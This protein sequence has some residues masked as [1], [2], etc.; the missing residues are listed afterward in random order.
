[1]TASGLTYD[2]DDQDLTTFV[3]YIYAE[4]W[5]DD[6]LHDRFVPEACVTK[7]FAEGV[8]WRWG[9]ICPSRHAQLIGLYTGHQGMA[10]FLGKFGQCFQV[11]AWRPK[12]IAVVKSDDDKF[13]AYVSLSADY[14]IRASGISL[15][16][17]ELHVLEIENDASAS[18]PQI[19]SV[20]ILFDELALE[21]ALQS[22][23]AQSGG[24]RKMSKAQRM[25]GAEAPAGI[26]TP[27]PQ[28]VRRWAR[29]ERDAQ[30]RYAAAVTVILAA[31][32]LLGGKTRGLLTK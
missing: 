6:L 2:P 13:T 5:A 11:K 22:P 28:V 24:S 9:G 7:H 26:P 8:E 31:A 3:T 10:E 16:M 14:V 1:M 32:L 25:L 12:S 30:L 17:D 20:N 19:T 21:S 23:S 27:H 18:E 4:Y 29:K 15:H